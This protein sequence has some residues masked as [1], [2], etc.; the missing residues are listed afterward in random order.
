VGLRDGPTPRRS[1]FAVVL[2]GSVTWPPKSGAPAT[3]DDTAHAVSPDT[4]VASAP[5]KTGHVAAA[6][7]RGLFRMRKR[8]PKV[9]ERRIFQE[10]TNSENKLRGCEGAQSRAGYIAFS[11]EP[12]VN[13]D[14]KRCQVS[15]SLHAVVS[16]YTR[17]AIADS[18]GRS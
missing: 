11:I 9:G 13:S 17:M 5:T 7:N 3:A 10:S 1:H 14:V 18:R 8:D 16:G 6:E 4:M 2:T 12:R 15:A